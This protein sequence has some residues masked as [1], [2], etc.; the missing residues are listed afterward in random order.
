[1]AKVKYEDTTL[2]ITALFLVEAKKI[3]VTEYW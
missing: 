3:E 2:E 1:M